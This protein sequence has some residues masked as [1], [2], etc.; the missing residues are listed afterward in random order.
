MKN[1]TFATNRRARFDYDLSDEFVAG[2]VLEGH[3]VKSIRRGD[4]SLKGAYVTIDTAH[5]A[6][7]TNAHVKKYVHASTLSH[8]DPERP[9]KLLL[10][11]SE[12]EKLVR[13]RQDKL[14]IVPTALFAAGPYIKLKLAIARPKKRSDKRQTIQRRDVERETR[15]RF[16]N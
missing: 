6:W 2:I 14:L 3:E 5:E 11:S 15:R 12:I 7:L 9:R 10:H 1:S 13:A 4:V 16:K 8:Y